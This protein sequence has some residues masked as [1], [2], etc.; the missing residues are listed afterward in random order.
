MI[1][2]IDIPDERT[3]LISEQGLATLKKVGTK[4]LREIIDESERIANS[5]SAEDTNPEITATTV[6]DAEVFYRKYRSIKKTKKGLK[7]IQICSYVSSLL[8]G[9]L[10]EPSKLSSIPY[11]SLFFIVLLTAII[12]GILSILLGDQND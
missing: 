1:I 11:F 5:Q 4:Y 2:E 7:Y 6:S 9:F 12:T 10:F 3:K 8:A